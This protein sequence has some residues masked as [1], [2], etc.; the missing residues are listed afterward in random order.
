MSSLDDGSLATVEASYD[1][2]DYDDGGLLADSALFDVDVD[3]YKQ[4]RLLAASFRAWKKRAIEL[5]RQAIERRYE[6]ENLKISVSY[7]EMHAAGRYFR[8]WKEKKK[9]MLARAMALM[10]GN[11]LRSRFLWWLHVVRHLRQAHLKALRFWV[12]NSRRDFFDR[13][14][15]FASHQRALYAISNGPTC[16]PVS[17]WKR[18]HSWPAGVKPIVSP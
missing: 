17:D 14:V 9:N 1:F 5:R 2:A 8:M 13:W 4:F 3:S 6:L 15:A 7:W 18:L 10:N 16:N 12:G 11:S